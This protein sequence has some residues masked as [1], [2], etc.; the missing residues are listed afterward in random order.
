M[1]LV[2]KV[3]LTSNLRGIKSLFKFI[4][5]DLG[6]NLNSQFLSPQNYKF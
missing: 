5:S 6:N 2:S 3:S 4:K 1:D